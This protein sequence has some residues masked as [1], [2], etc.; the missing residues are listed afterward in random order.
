MRCCCGCEI[1]VQTSECLSCSCVNDECRD[2]IRSAC[3]DADRTGAASHQCNGQVLPDVFQVIK[4]CFL[5]DSKGWKRE[6]VCIIFMAIFVSSA[7]SI[8]ENALDPSV[9]EKMNWRRGHHSS[10]V[11]ARYHEAVGPGDEDESVIDS[12][13]IFITRRELQCLKVTAEYR[14]L[15]ND[16]VRFACKEPLNG[17]DQ[18]TTSIPRMS[19]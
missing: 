14:S 6:L 17:I 10:M 9:Q 7:P 16:D 11:F 12:F 5:F 1:S 3:G 19:R 13:N 15:L 2:L 18:C 4:T 8:I